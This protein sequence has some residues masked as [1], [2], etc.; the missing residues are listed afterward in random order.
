MR[1]VVPGVTVTA[2]DGC[3]ISRC[4]RVGE[5]ICVA[6]PEVEAE[7]RRSDCSSKS[8]TYYNIL[9]TKDDAILIPSWAAWPGRGMSSYYRL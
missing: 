7:G 5:D 1:R 4:G 3:L 2:R 8:P 6:M 9:F